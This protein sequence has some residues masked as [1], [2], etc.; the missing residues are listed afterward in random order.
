MLEFKTSTNLLVPVVLTNA[1]SGL[2]HTGVAFGSVSVTVVKSDGSTVSYTP[3]VGQWTEITTGA[4][5]GGGYYNLTIP[6]ADANL[7][8]ILQYAVAVTGDDLHFGVVNIVDELESD[9][10]ARIG[11]PV[12]ASISADLQADTT[13]LAGDITSSTTSIKGASNKDLTQVDTDVGTAVTDITAVNTK[14]GTPAGASVSADIAAVK[15]DTAATLTSVARILGLSYDNVNEDQQVYSSGHLTSARLRLYDTAAHALAGGATGLL[16]TY[17]IAAA[18][19]ISGNC[20][21]F[22]VTRNP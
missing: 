20:T 19:D 3:T 22:T 4:Y 12:G 17:A 2:A 9:T 15:S 6:A 5:S 13:T 10:F 21:S 16:Y 7:A 1:T 14:L 8:G 11:A 18:Y